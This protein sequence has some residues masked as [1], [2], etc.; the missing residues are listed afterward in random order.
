V[1]FLWVAKNSRLDDSF[2]IGILA[3]DV[4]HLEQ[5]I[6]EFS[7]LSQTGTTIVASSPVMKHGLDPEA[8]VGR[9]R[10]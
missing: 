7:T 9:H 6:S 4:K 10:A 1:L 3:R 2:L 8:A 5:I